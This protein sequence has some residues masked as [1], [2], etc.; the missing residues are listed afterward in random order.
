MLSLE[1]RLLPRLL[2]GTYSTAKG[3]I[4]R[5]FC[6]TLSPWGRGLNLLM[7]A[8]EFTNSGEG[9]ISVKCELFNKKIS[10]HVTPHTLH[11]SKSWIASLSL[12][13]TAFPST[14]EGNLLHCKGE[15]GGFFLST[16]SRH[17]VPPSPRGRGLIGNPSGT[18]R[19][20]SL[21]GVC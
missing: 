10:C 13:M 4:G 12:A 9:L 1:W 5:I 17:Y 16:L 15:I 7:S 21:Q 6:T 18:S 19:N 8:S 11:F 3:E 2:K 20:L 14:L